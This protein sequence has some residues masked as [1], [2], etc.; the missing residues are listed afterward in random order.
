MR[1]R[2]DLPAPGT[3]VRVHPGDHGWW[4]VHAG[5]GMPRVALVPELELADAR[6]WW[7]RALLQ[8]CVETG[9]RKVCA[10]IEGRL[11]GWPTTPVWG[12]TRLD[13]TPD[14]EAPFRLRGE[15]GAP[16]AAWSGS[17]VAVLA[18]GEVWVG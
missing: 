13:Y 2:G 11:V 6:P 7:D 14:P 10:M 15:H 12:L 4:S 8:R 1:P 18:G 3:L 9:R 17:S 16:G 5:E